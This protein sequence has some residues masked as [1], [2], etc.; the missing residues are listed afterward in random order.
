MPRFEAVSGRFLSPTPGGAYTAT[1]SPHDDPARRVLLAL[2]AGDHTPALTREAAM[3]W[4]GLEDA[5]AALEV[6]YRLQSLALVQ[7]GSNSRAAAPEALEQILPDLLARLS[8]VGRALLADAQ[9]FYL[10]TAGFPHETAEELSA[11]T[12]DLASLHLRHSRLLQNNLGLP[13]SNWALVD[14]AG[15][16]R[17]GAWPMYVGEE[18]FA[19]VLAGTPRLNQPAFV[20]LAWALTRRYAHLGRPPPP[21]AARTQS[22]HAAEGTR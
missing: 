10:A 6:V 9:G 3:E 18:R 19:L 17:I 15:N 11:L 21:A 8:N 12:A 14:A 5:Q 13:V 16:S 4:S 20:D 1:A 2:M 22:P 7:A